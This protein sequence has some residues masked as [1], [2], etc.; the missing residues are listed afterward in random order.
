MPLIV[1]PFPAINQLRKLSI[2]I[3]DPEPILTRTKK[4]GFS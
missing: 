4:V 3:R 1:L 2:F